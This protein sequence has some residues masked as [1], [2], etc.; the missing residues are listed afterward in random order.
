VVLLV[1]DVEVFCVVR[2]LLLIAA[3]WEGVVVRETLDGLA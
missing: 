2:N 1:G 3:I